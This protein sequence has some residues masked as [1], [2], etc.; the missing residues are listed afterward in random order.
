ML[1]EG[2]RCKKLKPARRALR[3]FLESHCLMIIETRRSALAFVI[4]GLMH[5][6]TKFL[7]TG[8]AAISMFSRTLAAGDEPPTKLESPDKRFTVEIKDK[9]MPAAASDFRDKSIVI[10][11][12][13]KP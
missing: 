12:Q 3:A 4:F 13:G 1:T 5:Q 2:G 6:L 8:L 9:G 10:L 7:T 11:D